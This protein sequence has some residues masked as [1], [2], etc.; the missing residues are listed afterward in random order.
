MTDCEAVASMVSKGD[1][2]T[3][4]LAE[5]LN[6][7]HKAKL[8]RNRLHPGEHGPWEGIGDAKFATTEP[9]HWFNNIHPHCAIRMRAPVEHEH[10]HPIRCQHQHRGHRRADPQPISADNHQR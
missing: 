3:I 9:V 5:A 10:A 1:S 4:A 2:Y 8:V 7:S 6:S